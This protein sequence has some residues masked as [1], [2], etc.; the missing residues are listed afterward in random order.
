MNI[1]V[2]RS[3]AEA[4][5]GSVT[6]SDIETVTPIS[7]SQVAMKGFGFKSL[8]Q[9]EKVSYYD[10]LVKVHKL[11]KFFEQTDK[12]LVLGSTFC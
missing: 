7:A 11:A 12:E 4:H 3:F 2:A 10:M 6:L 9:M 5:P 1:D 8:E